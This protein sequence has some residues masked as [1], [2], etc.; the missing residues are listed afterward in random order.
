MS[1][2]H[3]LSRSGD[4]M[5]LPRSIVIKGQRWR[6]CQRKELFDDDGDSCEGLC[7]YSE[8]KIFIKRGLKAEEKALT[9]VHEVFHAA[10]HELHIDLGH[11]MNESVTDG[12]TSILNEHFKFRIRR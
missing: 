12:V 2:A 7:D 3:A 6:V 1:L 10:M 11:E 5:K 8:K 4:V 9:F